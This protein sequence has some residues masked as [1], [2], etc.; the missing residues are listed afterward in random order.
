MNRLID[1]DASGVQV[2][3]FRGAEL[4]FRGFGHPELLLIWRLKTSSFTVIL[5]HH[6]TFDSFWVGF[7]FKAFWNQYCPTLICTLSKWCEHFTSSW[8][9]NYGG[10]F[11]NV[12]NPTIQ[13]Y[14]MTTSQV[15]AQHKSE[16]VLVSNIFQ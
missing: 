5:P 11:L 10:V 3:V 1:F 8:V 12:R 16:S 2:G 13:S 6:I 7:W 4:I 14:W 15:V 9:W